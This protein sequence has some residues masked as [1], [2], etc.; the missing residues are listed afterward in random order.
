MLVVDPKVHSQD[1]IILQKALLETV[2]PNIVVDGYAGKNTLRELN[3]FAL[4]SDLPVTNSFAGAAFELISKYSEARFVRD[5]DYVEAASKLGCKESHIRAVAE[6]EARG[7]GF[8]SKG[9]VKLLFERHKFYKY[10]GEALKNLDTRARIVSEMSLSV[11]P[12]ATAK[13]VLDLIARANPDICN[14]ASGGYKGD[15]Y[16]HDRLERAVAIDP[17]SGYMSASYGMYQ[18]MGFNHLYAGFHSA[19]DMYVSFSESEKNQFKGFVNFIKNNPA[20][21]KAIVAGDWLAFAKGYNGAAFATNDYNN[22]AA[23]AELKYR[24]YNK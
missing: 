11:A 19:I 2:A 8:L 24:K 10:L 20:I 23:K 4:A 21:H 13:D 5:E 15:I 6:I 12:T 22:K 1:A 14:A 9:R 7:N 3:T 17:E 18:I 16:E